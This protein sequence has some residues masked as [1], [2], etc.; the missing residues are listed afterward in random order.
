ML[1]VSARADPTRLAVAP[2]LGAGG[3]S[4]V[5]DDVHESPP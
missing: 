4:F 3:E 1:A 2:E 5:L